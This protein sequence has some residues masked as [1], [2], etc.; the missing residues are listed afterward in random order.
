MSRD[1]NSLQVQVRN[2]Q[3]L[4]FDGELF[5]ITAYNS[6]GVFDV[7]PQHANFISMIKKRVILRQADGR[8]DEI[9]LENGVMMVENNK[10]VVFL[11]VSKM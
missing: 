10:V 1:G 3:G 4:V 2:R 6:V 9:S 7:L 11:G 8:T 5:A